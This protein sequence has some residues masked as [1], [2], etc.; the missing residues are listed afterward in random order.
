MEAWGAAVAGARSLSLKLFR[1][2]RV[3]ASTAEHCGHSGAH[4]SP[5]VQGSRLP[6]PWQKLAV[7]A[8][9]LPWHAR[10][11][12]PTFIMIPYLLKVFIWARWIALFH[13]LFTTGMWDKNF[14]HTIFR[15]A[16]AQH[17]NL[18]MSDCRVHALKPS[19]CWAVLYLTLS[20]DPPMLKHSW[21]RGRIMIVKFTEHL[22]NARQFRETIWI[23][24]F[25]A[26][27]NPRSGYSFEL[28][29]TN[30]Q[31]VKPGNTTFNSDTS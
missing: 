15:D 6:H 2:Q 18:S 20:T 27:N 1:R 29:L 24:A 23:I 13:W 10:H 9:R 16:T 11:P 30:S 4:A 5:P 3:Q 17:G 31:N 8:V 19:L 22:W 12:F 7:G 25:N 21:L 14:Y 28:H 26:H